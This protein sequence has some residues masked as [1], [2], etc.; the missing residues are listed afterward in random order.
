MRQ[1]RDK[2]GSPCHGLKLEPTVSRVDLGAM[3]RADR[4]PGVHAKRRRHP[5]GGLRHNLPDHRPTACRSHACA[6]PG[7]SIIHSGNPERAS[8]GSRL[9]RRSEADDGQPQGA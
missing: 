1:P 5:G 6:R 4:E 3:G 9:I 2:L 8:G 7:R